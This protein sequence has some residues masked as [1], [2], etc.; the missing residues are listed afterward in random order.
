GGGGTS[1]GGGI[2]IPGTSLSN[3]GIVEVILNPNQY[4]KFGLTPA[5]VTTS[6]AKTTATTF[7][8]TVTINGVP[9][10]SFTGYDPVL[11][12][13]PYATSTTN[14]D[15]LVVR[16]QNGSIVPR[17]LYKDGYLYVNT[18]DISG[19]FTIVENGVSFGDISSATHDWAMTGVNALAAR[20][21]INGVGN[22]F[23]EPNRSVT[24]AEFIKMVVS[25]FNVYDP[26]AGA[27]FTDVVYGEWYNTYVG[28]AQALG[29]TK[30]YED[31]SFRP[32]DT[33]SREEMSTM[34][35]RAAEIL[36]VAIETTNNA[37]EFAD[38]WNI[39]DYAKLPVYKMRNAGILN[40]VGD[41][42]F[43]PKNDCTRAQ[44]A[45]AIYN[46]FVISMAR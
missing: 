1:S 31:G 9:T 37:G 45:V 20:N 24:R 32:N 14:K 36:S 22:G 11:M 29:I 19:V 2:V 12:K 27:N 5:S 7:V 13:V 8:A 44:A 16:A 17:T 43:D 23:Y 42:M 39:Q 35:Y 6:G 33:I 38:D 26:S 4:E 40:G 34:L 28:T 41:N 15:N 18:N 3:N 21:I 10:T 25:M 30:G 46:M